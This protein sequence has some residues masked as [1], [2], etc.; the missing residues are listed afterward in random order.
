MK[1]SLSSS[2]DV[3]DKQGRFLSLRQAANYIGMSPTTVYRLT[4]RMTNRLPFYKVGK[5]KLFRLE[6]IDAWMQ[7]HRVDAIAP[8]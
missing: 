3:A 6:D 8:Y 4:Y 7:Q 5:L 2:V 1:T